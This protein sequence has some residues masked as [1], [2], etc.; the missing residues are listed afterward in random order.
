MTIARHLSVAPEPQATP[1]DLPLSRTAQVNGENLAVFVN[2]DGTPTLTRYAEMT[3]EEIATW[4]DPR[5][6]GPI[7]QG[8]RDVAQGRLLRDF[9]WDGLWHA[10]GVPA[11]DDDDE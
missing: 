10:L 7:N 2:F 5:I 1:A 8:L 6:S 11:E 9:G 4:E 3:S